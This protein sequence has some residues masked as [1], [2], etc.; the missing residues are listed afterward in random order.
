MNASEGTMNGLDSG[1]LYA[2][3]PPDTLCAMKSVVFLT[4]LILSAAPAAYAS[5]W[6]EDYAEAEH[7]LSERDWETAVS[8]LSSAIE[9]K[10]D[11]S[12]RARTYG[13][14]FIS[15]FPY[16]KLGMAFY[17]LGDYHNAL[18]TFE[19]EQRLGEIQRSARDHAALE[20]FRELTLS[21]QADQEAQRDTER[22]RIVRQSKERALALEDE[23]KL[24][25]ALESLAAA[26]AVDPENTDLLGLM[27]RL[28]DT[29]AQRHQADD[30][31]R[32]ATALIARG[33]ELLRSDEFNQAASL[34]RQAQ[35]LDPQADISDLLNQAEQG[36][37]SSFTKRQGEQQLSEVTSGIAE[38]RSLA[39]KGLTTQALDRLQPVLALAPSNSEARALLE[40]LLDLKQ[41]EQ[42]A[43]TVQQAVELAQTRL[44]AGEFEKALVA[45]HRALALDAHNATA[46]AVV[47]RAYR[48]IST[49]LLGTGL[50]QRMPPAIR[51]TDHRSDQGDGVLAQHVSTAAVR[52]SGL[53]IS[54]TPVA[55]TFYINDRQVSGSTTS[56]L[57]AEFYITQFLLEGRLSPGLTTAHV[58]ATDRLGLRSSSEYLVVYHRPFVKSPWFVLLIGTIAGALAGGI[59]VR[60]RQRSGRLRRRRFNPYIAGAPVLDDALFFGRQELVDNILQTIHHN[61]LLLFGERRIGKTSLQHHL[62]RRLANLDDPDYVFYPVFIDLQGTPQQAFFQTLAQEIADELSPHLEGV[63]LQIATG[64]GRDYGFRELV[65]DLRMVV[66]A[67]QQRSAKRLKL[68]LLIDEVDELNDYDPRINQQLRSLFM[69]S[70][71]EHLVAVVSG[72]RIR[73]EW[74]REASPWYNFFEEVEVTGIDP[75]QAAAL[76]TTPLKGVFK[77]K[78]AAVARIV[79]LSQCKPYLIQKLCIAV[80]QQA[81]AHKRSAITS[82]D[83]EAVRRHDAP[84]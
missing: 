57:T 78:P 56:Q 40:R 81:H 68:V 58:I 84:S 26:V 1:D 54:S 38:A 5:T 45:A 48:H 20:R 18:L 31:A 12:A 13:M 34:F 23:G 73:R 6:Y 80:V 10:A 30:D 77:V 62:K 32:R 41:Q 75:A 36:L 17:Q 33:T 82:A 24:D 59:W 44:Q 52:L 55:M 8:L 37:R 39:E 67:V 27:S 15:Y 9:K 65:A 74:D 47:T 50:T 63:E 35:A 42:R 51:F 2:I 19:T 43:S 49:S 29:A 71:A 76:V 25:E 28:R 83:V 70:F 66:A 64:Q 46:L 79:E 22:E 3:L 21:A 61:S 7:A 69:K 72:V 53:A 60:R 16:F 11:S 4:L 14:K